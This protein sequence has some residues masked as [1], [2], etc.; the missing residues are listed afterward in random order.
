MRKK[1]IYSDIFY[2]M[3]NYV[4]PNCPYNLSV[5]VV[6]IPCIVVTAVEVVV[7]VVDTSVVL[8][9]CF[10]APGQS[11]SLGRTKFCC[12]MFSDHHVLHPG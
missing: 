1:Y 4:K 8:S 10:Q 12:S 5:V 9:V 6:A 7:L 11:Q 2:N 3:E